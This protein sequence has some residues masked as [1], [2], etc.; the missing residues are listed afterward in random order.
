MFQF[1]ESL[2][3]TLKFQEEIKGFIAEFIIG[4]EL[5]NSDYTSVF[6]FENAQWKTKN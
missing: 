4:K 6:N 2:S 3:E 1:G 5:F